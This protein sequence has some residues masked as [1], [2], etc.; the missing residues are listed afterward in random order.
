VERHTIKCPSRRF[1]PGS[2]LAVDPFVLRYRSTRVRVC[3]SIPQGE[4]LPGQNHFGY[5]FVCRCT[6][7]RGML[8]EL[9]EM[10]S[11]HRE[12]QVHF[13]DDQQTVEEGHNI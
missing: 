10:L 1:P 4:R 13:I 6:N 8:K 12:H 7:Q 11:A 2:P 5:S 9:E 3:P